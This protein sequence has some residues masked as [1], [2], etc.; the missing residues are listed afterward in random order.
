MNLRSPTKPKLANSSKSFVIQPPKSPCDRSW[1]SKA[2][3]EP[4]N[5]AKPPTITST[6]PPGI[7]SHSP[8]PPTGL[9][10]AGTFTNAKCRSHQHQRSEHGNHTIGHSSQRISRRSKHL[11]LSRRSR[12]LDRPIYSR[13][14][15]TSGSRWPSSA[16]L[17]SF[18]AL[19]PALPQKNPIEID[20]AYLDK[21][22]CRRHVYPQHRQGCFSVPAEIL[23]S[24]PHHRSR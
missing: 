19:C 11:L 16:L 17:A 9:R 3:Q 5:T 8:A 4:T 13:L 21:H 14:S 7:S 12:N 1:R 10:I 18:S 22:L 24:D 20:R 2:K 23:R 15:L 6:P